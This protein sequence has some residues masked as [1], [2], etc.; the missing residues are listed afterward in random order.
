[1][2][3]PAPFPLPH[4]SGVALIIWCPIFPNHYSGNRPL[5]PMAPPATA[6]GD[7]AAALQCTYSNQRVKSNMHRYTHQS[8]TNSSAL[9]F[10][11]HRSADHGRWS[12]PASTEEC[13]GRIK[14]SYITTAQGP[15][16]T[17]ASPHVVMLMPL[18]ILRWQPH[19]HTGR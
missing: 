16:P 3:K 7:N 10:I 5:M 9:C 19:W 15:G 14:A 6:H 18:R 4:P 17:A 8:E 11:R 1:M 12:S 2:S 13:H